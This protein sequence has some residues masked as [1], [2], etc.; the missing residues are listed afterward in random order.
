MIL[1]K[2]ILW[3]ESNLSLNVQFLMNSACPDPHFHM[4]FMFKL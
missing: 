3:I 1:N 4:I 2:F